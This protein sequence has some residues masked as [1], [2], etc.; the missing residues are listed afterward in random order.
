MERT[1]LG[2]R[3]R[4]VQPICGGQFDVLVATLALLVE[5]VR[6]R[7]QLVHDDAAR[8]EIHALHP[9]SYIVVRTLS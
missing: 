2:D 3:G 1:V 4:E 8:P 5:R 6:A 9:L 7:Q